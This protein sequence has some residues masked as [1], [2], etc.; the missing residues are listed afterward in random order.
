MKTGKID[1]PLA[2]QKTETDAKRQYRGKG[3]GA[4][5]RKT[6]AKN[7]LEHGKE[8]VEILVKLHKSFDYPI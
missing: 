2:E 8:K 4:L 7:G 1:K 5:K 6:K 3:P